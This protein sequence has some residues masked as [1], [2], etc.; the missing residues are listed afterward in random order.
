M[1][2]RNSL[3]I[4]SAKAVLPTS[5][6][7]SGGREFAYGGDILCPHCGC[8]MSKE[9][10]SQR[11]TYDEV[12]LRATVA[13]YRQGCPEYGIKYYMPTVVLERAK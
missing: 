6:P 5:Q 13:C 12:L 7:K 3:T 9:V 4:D 11:A 10:P 8:V 2:R 1:N